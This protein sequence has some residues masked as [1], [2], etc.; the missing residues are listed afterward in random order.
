MP[1]R[2]H[3]L[4]H[5]SAKHLSINT[6]R[7]APLRKPPHGAKSG[8]VDMLTWLSTQVQNGRPERDLEI[9][10]AIKIRLIDGQPED[11][12]RDYQRCA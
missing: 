3:L 12:E 7:V 6:K 5:F 2:Q 10:E 9:I 4:A 8:L 1:L 11:D